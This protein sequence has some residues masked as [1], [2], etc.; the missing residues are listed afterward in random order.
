M[1]NGPIPGES[2]TREPGNAPWEQPPQFA[3]VEKALAM[4]MDKLEED[5]EALE[6][7][8]FILD[9]G[10]PLDLFVETLLLN[11][12]M[13]GKH[14]FDVS[15]LIGPVLHEHLLS[16]AEAAGASVREFQGATPEGKSR[17]KVI[18][19]LKLIL[20]KGN[21]EVGEEAT[22]VLDE[23]VDKLEENPIET[24]PPEEA[25]KGLMGRRS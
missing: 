9:E 6:D 8:L 1:L 17:E 5:D 24:A 13:E 12:E 11:S 25:P 3:T 4:Y 20:Q 22:E 14:T 15:I 16:L 19:D 18:R 2:L 23:A 7:I 21:S 10:F